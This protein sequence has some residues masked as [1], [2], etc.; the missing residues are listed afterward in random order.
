MTTAQFVGL[1]VDLIEADAN[2]DDDADSIG[3]PELRDV[4][5]EL[6]GDAGV[7]TRDEGLVVTLADGTQFE[8]TA[9]QSR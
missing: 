7:M 3:G 5:V 2:L 8:L 9:V 1:L 6:F 4:R